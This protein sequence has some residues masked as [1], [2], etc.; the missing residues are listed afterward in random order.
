MLTSNQL[1]TCFFYLA[2]VLGA[3]SFFWSSEPQAEGRNPLILSEVPLLMLA[4][5]GQEEARTSLYTLH[6][7]TS[8][9]A[10]ISTSYCNFSGCRKSTTPRTTE[11]QTSVWFSSSLKVRR[12]SL[13]YCCIRWVQTKPLCFFTGR[14]KASHPWDSVVVFSRR[15][16]CFITS[17]SV[18]GQQKGKQ[19]LGCS[20]LT[21]NGG[22]L[23]KVTFLTFSQLPGE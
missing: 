14:Q 6:Y 17:S 3:C 22:L 18:D 10:T 8:L 21:N 11:A 16:N 5:E 12:Q 23:G 13:L 9:A 4:G 19:L 2:S 1:S 7:S 15:E 20:T